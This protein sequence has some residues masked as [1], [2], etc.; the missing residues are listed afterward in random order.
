M[1]DRPN[2]L[3]LFYKAET[4]PEKTEDQKQKRDKAG[5]QENPGST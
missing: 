5:N 1:E 2:R 4:G 3:G